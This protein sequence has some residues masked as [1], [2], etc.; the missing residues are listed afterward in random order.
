[1]SQKRDMGHPA[2]HSIQGDMVCSFVSPVALFVALSLLFFF[3]F[4]SGFIFLITVTPLV[5]WVRRRC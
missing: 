1:M 4:L 5:G 2:G 3:W